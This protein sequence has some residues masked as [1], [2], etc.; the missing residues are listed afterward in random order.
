MEHEVQLF[1]ASTVPA[2]LVVVSHVLTRVIHWPA[3]ARKGILC[4]GGRCALCSQGFRPETRY[5][6]RVEE[7]ESVPGLRSTQGP[8]RHWVVELRERFQTLASEIEEACRSNRGTVLELV[9]TGPLRNSP[10]DHRSLG[11]VS[12]RNWFDIGPFAKA[13]YEEAVVF[14]EESIHELIPSPSGFGRFEDTGS[15]LQESSSPIAEI[16]RKRLN[17]GAEREMEQAD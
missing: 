13:L 2:E 6:F 15:R 3:G 5:L 1:R 11:V 14:R 7:R 4:G 10:I 17:R 16:A 12:W 9:K 8:G